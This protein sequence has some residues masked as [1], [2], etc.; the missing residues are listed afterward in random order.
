M[1][2]ALWLARKR[3]AGWIFVTD[4]TGLNAYDKLPTGEYWTSELQ[5]ATR[6]ADPR[7]RVAGGQHG[8]I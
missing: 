4:H 3:N 5:R 8:A 6:S 7:R 1:R 2:T